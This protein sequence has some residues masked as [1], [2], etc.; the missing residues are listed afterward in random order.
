M[1]HLILQRNGSSRDYVY[2]L[3]NLYL[4]ARC[5]HL[6]QRLNLVKH[7]PND[8]IAIADLMKHYP[9][10]TPSGIFNLCEM[11][12]TV[13][14]LSI[15]GDKIFPGILTPF[16]SS[17]DIP[18]INPDNWNNAY[19]ILEYLENRTDFA[20]L[21]L[22]DKVKI[23]VSNNS[24]TYS[25]LAGES[26]VKELFC[27]YVLASAIF[28]GTKFNFFEIISKHKDCDIILLLGELAATHSGIN[29]TQKEKTL[30]QILKLFSRYGLL[31]IT[32][33]NTFQPNEYTLHLTSVSQG[34]LIPSML[35]IDSTWWAS[36]GQLE[37]S[38]KLESKSAFEVASSSTFQQYIQRS[39]KFA[40]GMAAISLYEDRDV[41]TVLY[42]KIAQYQ[43]IIDIGGG[44]GGLLHQLYSTYPSKNYILFEKEG[45]DSK[46]T[47]EKRDEILNYF[48]QTFGR[49]KPN[50]YLGDFNK[51][52]GANNIPKVDNAVYIIKC[53]LHN[54]GDPKI[55]IEILRKIRLSMGENCILI[56]AERIAPETYTRPHLNRTGTILM[57]MLFKADTLKIGHY[58]Y[59]LDTAGFDSIEIEQANNYFVFK[60]MAKPELQF[61]KRTTK[62]VPNFALTSALPE[63]AKSCTE[64]ASVRKQ[65]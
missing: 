8:G 2:E 62:E 37:C 15:L 65:I 38:L 52:V 34:N 54:I 4:T 5:V 43:T 16:Y 64:E 1:Y 36:A 6:G 50:L 57:R 11:L 23:T 22:S 7:V 46:D 60:A 24:L 58:R 19:N 30:T 28:F 31:N 14:L 61:Q 3:S 9:E 51:N 21:I 55:I 59:I 26:L 42:P 18:E 10:Y 49:F 48:A 56:L 53:V 35:Q 33:N 17:L 47:H 44:R 12:A 32:N 25:S 40:K 63:N 41:A 27:S 13:Q 29:W 45:S 20:E 39:D